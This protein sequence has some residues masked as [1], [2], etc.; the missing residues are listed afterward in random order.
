M[1]E[2]EN[3]LAE[4]RAENQR[5]SKVVSQFEFVDVEYYGSDYS[6]EVHVYHGPPQA[7]EQVD[8]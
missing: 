4:L 8:G 7:E 2:L 6:T 3:Q 5:L 1:N